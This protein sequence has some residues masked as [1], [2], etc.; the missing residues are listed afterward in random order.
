MTTHATFGQGAGA[1][2]LVQAEPHI[3][4][5]K[6]VRGGVELRPRVSVIEDVRKQKQRTQ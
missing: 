1:R 5:S 4:H 3:C 2:L 6:S